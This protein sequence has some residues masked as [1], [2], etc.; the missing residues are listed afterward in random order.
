MTYNV[1]KKIIMLLLLTCWVGLS[2]A[3]EYWD[4]QRPDKSLTVGLRAG[5]NFAKQYNAADGADNDF[6][7]G[8]RA[9]VEVDLNFVQSFSLNSGIF[10]IQKG[11]KSEYSDYRGSLNTDDDASYLEMP[12]LASYRVKLSDAAQFQLNLGPYYA[13]GLSGKHKVKSTFSGQPDY[14]IDSFDEY[15][16]LKKSDIGIHAGA[17]ISF[18]GYYVGVC[19]ERSMMNVSNATGAK[20]RNG[21]IGITL[22]YNI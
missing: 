14:E 22:G 7:L 16:G 3:Q 2:S 8:Y 19:Y 15:D 21:G 12:L 20:Y 10:F 1:M 18:D 6:R 13:F 17:A 9:G 4:G 11:Y 5:L